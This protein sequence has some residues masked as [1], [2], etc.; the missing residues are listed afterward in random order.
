MKLKLFICL[1]LAAFKSTA[2]TILYYKNIIEAERCIIE[3]KLDSSIYFYSLSQNYKPILFAKDLYNAAVV[4]IKLKKHQTA[5]LH[6]KQ[7]IK[8]GA[9]TT[10]LAENNIYKEYFTNISQGAKLIKKSK[11]IKP[12]YDL[13]YRKKLQEL[14]I[15]DQYYRLKRGGDR[16][17]VDSIKIADAENIAKLLSMIKH[18]GFP[19]ED[20]VG[21]D[22]NSL[23]IPDV[24]T[25]FLHQGKGDLQQYDF[26]EILFE[27]VKKGELDNR[28]GYD[29][30]ARNKGLF[31]FDYMRFL[32]VEVIDKTKPAARRN[33]HIIIDS[34]DWGYLPYSSDEQVKINQSRKQFFLSDYNTHMKQ[35]LF[36]LKNT[37]F[38]FGSIYTGTS[39]LYTE[40]KG[41]EADRKKLIT[42]NW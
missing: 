31:Q 40:R 28:L 1:L 34:T 14:L 38:K 2:Q 39:A 18:K 33:N 7:L 30:Y 24:T 16:Q 32:L 5:N 26:S 23:S 12:T 10:V 6:I 36:N 41:F 13:D 42:F 4:A 21:I 37:E 29:L 8:L 27:Y 3:N 9:T 17:Y 19:S 25:I 22:P 15:R 11:S 35:I 20:R